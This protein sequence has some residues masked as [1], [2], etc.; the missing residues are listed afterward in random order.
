MNKALI[1]LLFIAFL[2]PGCSGMRRVDSQVSSFVVTPVAPGA[3]Y[4]FERLPSQQV[5]SAAQEAL[6]ALTEKA[7]AQVGLQRQ[8][9]GAALLV[10]VALSERSERT[11]RAGVLFGWP[12]GGHGRT[13]RAALLGAGPLFPGLDELP[14]YWRELHL[15]LRS[16]A[17]AALVFESRASHEGPWSDTGPIAGALLQAALQG[18][19]NPPPG[20][21][22]VDVEIAR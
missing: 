17:T 5:D 18:F 14:S 13:H 12:W 22:Q 20:P 4:R 8:D 3:R 21:R 7:L 6:E 16:T 9:E 10:Q 15:T 19:P 11:L 1:A 2:L